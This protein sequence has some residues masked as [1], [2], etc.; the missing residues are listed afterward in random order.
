M[1]ATNGADPPRGERRIGRI[2]VRNLW[3]LMLYAS[4][5]TRT[6]EA[7][8]AMVDE[9]PEDL[10]DL[11]ARL[12]ADAVERRLRRNLTRGYHRREMALARVRGRIDVLTTESRQLLSKGEVFCRFE[13]LSMDTPRN[14]LVR[15]AL[16]RMAR[17]VRDAGTAH[18]CRSL[19]TDLSQAG[20]GGV[21]PSRADLAA[22]QIGRNNADDRFMVA[23][24]RLAFDLALPTEEAGP[25]PFAAPDREEAWARRLFEKAVLGFARVELEPRGWRVRGSTPLEWQVS[26]ATAGLPA[27]LPCMVTDIV[28]DPPNCG[29]RVVIDTKFTSILASGR[30]CGATLKS[31]YLYQ[32]Y[33][34]LRSQEGPDPRWDDAAGLFLHPAI[35]AVLHERAV[36]QRHA[37]SFAT[38]DLSG[39][40][41][42]IRDGLRSLLRAGLDSERS[43][44]GSSA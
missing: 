32:M 13:D 30:F 23:L 18:R 38:I 6:R 36:I 28:L 44:D 10:P 5:L 35:G 16:D 3:L 1:P 24:A 42:A 27:I 15:A 29:R 41:V 26:S 33:A 14:R 22:D 2:P 8:D 40:A 12:L 21:R 17:L 37:I 20:V 11:V 43:K 9:D 7:F 31:G 34:Y 25:T 4:E 19:A 39:S